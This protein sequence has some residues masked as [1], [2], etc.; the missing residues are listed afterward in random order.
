MADLPK[1][2]SKNGRAHA[3]SEIS[4][5]QLSAA[6]LRWEHNMRVVMLEFNELTPRLMDR[7]IAAGQLPNF[8]K[9]QKASVTYL[10]DAQEAGPYLA[11]CIQ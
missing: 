3:G 2:Q 9:M 10:S 5:V 4:G 8:A 11:P 6:A 7:F 1:S